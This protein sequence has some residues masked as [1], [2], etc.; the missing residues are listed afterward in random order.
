MATKKAA[1]GRKKVG[2]LLNK[3]SEYKTGG[4]LESAIPNLDD[5]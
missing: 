5:L 2:K 4:F 3:I 1:K